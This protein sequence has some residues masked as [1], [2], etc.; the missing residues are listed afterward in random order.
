[1]LI[2]LVSD[3]HIDF[4]I[5]GSIA[6]LQRFN[7]NGADV[8]VVAGD[9]CQ[10]DFLSDGKANA[11]LER[12]ASKYNHM[13][14]VP[15][16]HDYYGL[17]LSFDEY[18]VSKIYTDFGFE[19][20]DNYNTTIHKHTF[21]GTT[22]W[23][24]NDPMNMFHEKRINDFHMIEEFKE[25]VYHRNSRG[26]HYL[27]NN[28]A[29]IFIT[30]HLPFP[31]SIA[32]QFACDSLNRFFLCDMS[33]KVDKFPKLWLHGH[34][35]IPCDYKIWVGHSGVCN[36]VCNPRGYP[37]ENRDWYNYMPLELEI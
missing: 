10:G 32:S 7:G 16:N 8:L 6:W 14:F 28:E 13:I 17:N 12:L 30:H 24:P 29:E 31:Q 37:H 15:G 20:L 33:D 35:H 34:T 26:V 23:F 11:F 25:N 9:T 18:K 19:V 3:L 22:L 5:A 36:V 27:G 4:N 1:M 2:H 21:A